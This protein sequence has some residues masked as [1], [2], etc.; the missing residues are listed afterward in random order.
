MVVMALIA[1][2]VGGISL[3]IS[4]ALKRERFE[5]GVDQVI[6]KITLAQEL[7][8]DFHT[9]VKLTLKRDNGKWVCDIN[10]DRKLPREQERGVNH[11]AEIKGVEEITFEGGSGENVEILFSGTLGVISPGTLTL[12]SQDHKA[13]IVLKGYPSQIKR[14]L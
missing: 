5:R 9:D 3:P 4:K 10:T 1:I 14:G 13:R 12:L 6:A 7:M 2:A 8:L 11:Y